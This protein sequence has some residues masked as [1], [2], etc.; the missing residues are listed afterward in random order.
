ML[1]KEEQANVFTCLHDG[2][3]TELLRDGDAIRI[4]VEIN[5]VA[6][7][8]DPDYTG[9]QCVLTDCRSFCFEL[10]DGRRVDNLLQILELDLEIGHAEVNNDDVA[11]Y[12]RCERDLEG[13]WCDE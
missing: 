9:F 7:L 13:N 2:G 11:V 4:F 10:Y 8:V 3:F 5:Y 1:G 12:C 6:E